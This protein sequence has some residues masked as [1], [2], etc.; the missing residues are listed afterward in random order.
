MH[1]HTPQVHQNIALRTRAHLTDKK[2]IY[3]IASKQNILLYYIFFLY[4][5]FYQ[6]LHQQG[7]TV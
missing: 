3:E 5:I 6:S 1:N 2:V 4:K 7:F